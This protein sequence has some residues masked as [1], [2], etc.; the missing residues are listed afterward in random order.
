MSD[1]AADLSAL[2]DRLA[3]RE[4]VVDAWTAKSFTD[5]LFVVEVPPEGRLPETVRETLHGHD[6][7]EADEVYEVEGAADADFAGDLADGRR[8][9]FVDV[10][11]R[12]DLQ[13][14]VVE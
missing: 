1:R 4:G 10:R 11:T 6:L 7:R 9:R 3:D 5:R 14:Y 2:A 8:Y 12:G 13:S